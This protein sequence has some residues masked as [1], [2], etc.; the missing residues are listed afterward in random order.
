MT[1]SMSP[2]P[3]AQTIP[4]APANELRAARSVT[5]KPPDAT[6]S[7]ISSF[8]TFIQTTQGQAVVRVEPGGSR[9]RIFAV[10]STQEDRPISFASNLYRS[11]S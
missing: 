8:R 1:A 9:Y 2:R 7:T 3:V 4:N 10:D 5:Q 11:R 6:R